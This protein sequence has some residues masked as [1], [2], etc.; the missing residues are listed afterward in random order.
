MS[1]RDASEELAERL[2]HRF[3]DPALLDRALTH[4]SAS[5]DG[6][7]SNARL[8]FL[9]DAVLATVVCE[10]LYRQFPQASEGQLTSL[11]SDLVRNERLT[12]AARDAGLGSY[13]R[14]G[15][16]LEA[17]GGRDTARVLADA[18][19][20]V[21]G[22]AY[23][24]GGMPAAREVVEKSLFGERGLSDSRFDPAT[25]NPK[26][27]LQEWLAAR[28]LPRPEYVI[29]SADGPSDRRTFRVRVSCGSHS[30][31]AEA[32]TKQGAEKIGAR[33]VLEQLIASEQG[34]KNAEAAT[35]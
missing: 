5:C 21:L 14:L 8:E 15:K 30:A 28:S 26:S 32:R 11:K 34:A 17:K 25:S 24:D 20:A 29:I 7:T 1:K 9:G 33:R 16:G 4:G 35:A 13:L 27:T 2:G 23:L 22:A 10:A 18:F 12:A 19:E 31:T 3:S 6:T